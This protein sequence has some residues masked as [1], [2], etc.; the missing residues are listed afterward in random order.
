MD[1]AREPDPPEVALLRRQL[2][3]ERRARLTAEQEGERATAEL[4]ETVQQLRAAQEELRVVAQDQQLMNELARELRRDLEPGL[5]LSRAAAAVGRATDAE[6]CVIRLAADAGIGP[7]VEQWVTRGTPRLEA[8]VQVADCLDRLCLQAAHS[9]TTLAIDDVLH[10]DRLTAEESAEI[11]HTLG[12]FSYAGAPMWAGQELVG[13]IALHTLSAATP[14]TEHQLALA[15]ALARDVA[16]ALL[17]SQAHRGQAEAM[18]RLQELDRVKSDFIST[19]SHELRTPLTSIAG[20]VELLTDP[21]LEDL[22]ERQTRMLEVVYRNTERLRRL[23]EDLLSLS[24]SDSGLTPEW[25][26]QLDVDEALSN[27]RAALAPLLR[28]RELTL[29]VDVARDL[30]EV[31]GRPDQLERILDNLLSNAV[32]FTPDGGRVRVTVDTHNDALVI[33]VEDTGHGIPEDELPYVFDRFFRT[34]TASDLAIQ[35]TGLGLAVT[36]ALVEEQGGTV[37]LTSAPGQGTTATVR[38]PASVVAPL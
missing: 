17:Q 38:L 12:V 16:V 22:T 21:E 8:D 29:E 26:A 18:T 28:G 24:S 4:Y 33:V 13:W 25:T 36:K 1:R 10:D 27:V 2:E 15:E 14:W 31:I 5:V 3:R 7:T 30:P 20:Y 23:V 34:R 11:H 37:V 9:N 32:K 19:V 6:R 35:G